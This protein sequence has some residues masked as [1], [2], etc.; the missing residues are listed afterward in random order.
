LHGVQHVRERTTM[1]GYITVVATT[2][3]ASQDSGEHTRCVMRPRTV[4]STAQAD[5]V[6]RFSGRHHT[7]VV[8]IH[9]TSVRKQADST[10]QQ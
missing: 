5:T 10:G 2:Y 3:K 8:S 4:E 7:L 9:H 6:T 1:L